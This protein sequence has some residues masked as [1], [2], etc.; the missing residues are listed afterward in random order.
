MISFEINFSG[1][2]SFCLFGTEQWFYLTF[3]GSRKDVAEPI[4]M[5]RCLI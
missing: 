2:E 1:A 4:F 3:S 5:D